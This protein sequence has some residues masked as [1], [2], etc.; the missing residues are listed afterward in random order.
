MLEIA[1]YN[2]SSM[3][4]GKLYLIMEEE[5]LTVDVLLHEYQ[6]WNSY[7]YSLILVSL[8]DTLLNQASCVLGEAL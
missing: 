6:L 3:H 5:L 7:N 2:P 4:L 1:G 8:L